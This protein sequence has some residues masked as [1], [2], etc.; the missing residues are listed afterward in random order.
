MATG[1]SNLIVATVEIV[2]RHGVWRHW[3]LSGV[4]VISLVGVSCVTSRPVHSEPPR[5]RPDDDSAVVEKIRQNSR[6]LVSLQKGGS[7]FEVALY[8]PDEKVSLINGDYC[9]A[10]TGAKNY[11]GTYQLVSIGEGRVVARTV[12]ETSFEFV[13]DGVPEGM[14]AL[15]MAKQE[16]VFV[17][18]S[19]VYGL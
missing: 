14:F 16:D 1:V 6:G 2:E 7:S 11:S 18:I 15:T 12:L 17:I 4:A 3:V 19:P 13:Y 10:N 5:P 9:R 8:A